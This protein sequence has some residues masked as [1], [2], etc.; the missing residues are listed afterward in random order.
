MDKTQDAWRPIYD[1]VDSVDEW[2]ESDLVRLALSTFDY[3]PVVEIDARS[4]PRQYTEELLAHRHDSR[5]EG[6]LIEAMSPDWGSKE[7]Y[8]T[9]AYIYS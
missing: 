2:I 3:V 5:M 9:P 4:V 6:A 8:T 1:L 7:W